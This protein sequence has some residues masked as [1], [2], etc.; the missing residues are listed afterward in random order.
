MRAV[1]SLPSKIASLARC[2]CGRWVE[3]T[4]AHIACRSGVSLLEPFRIDLSAIPVANSDQ[5]RLISQAPKRRPS[6][7]RPIGNRLEITLTCG[8]TLVRAKS[9]VPRF[10]RCLECTLGA[11]VNHL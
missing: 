1:E 2:S 9:R 8:H 3:N 4:D 5:R 10:V 6:I 7:T 11:G